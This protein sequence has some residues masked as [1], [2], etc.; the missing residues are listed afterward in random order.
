MDKQ[1]PA[2]ETTTGPTTV[3]H[4]YIMHASW[5]SRSQLAC[6]NL[7]RVRDTYSN[8]L[9]VHFEAIPLYVHKFINSCAAK[10][11]YEKTCV[12]RKVFDAGQDTKPLLRRCLRQQLELL[13]RQVE[14]RIER[15]QLVVLPVGQVF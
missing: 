10:C 12:E 8:S 14:I 3:V 6:S 2:A 9:V 4:M 15:A 13:Y 7:A 5:K 1:A 11:F